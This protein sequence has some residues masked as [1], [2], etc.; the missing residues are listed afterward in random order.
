MFTQEQAEKLADWIIA[1]EMKM[2]AARFPITPE[3]A[4]MSDDD[5]YAELTKG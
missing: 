2:I 4:A 3:I 1:Q 5:I